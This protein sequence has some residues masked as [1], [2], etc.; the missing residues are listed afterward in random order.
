MLCLYAAVMKSETQ[1][2]IPAKKGRKMKMHVF[3]TQRHR[4]VCAEPEQQQQQ[5][6]YLRASHLHTY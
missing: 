6:K 4:C 5:P 2:K 1:L 3:P